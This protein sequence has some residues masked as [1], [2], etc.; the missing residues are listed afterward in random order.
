MASNIDA[1]IPADNVKVDKADLRSN[2]SSAKSEIE[3]LQRETRLPW[4]IAI[5]VQT[6]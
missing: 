4:L 5:G 2:F 1:T 6:V 3:S